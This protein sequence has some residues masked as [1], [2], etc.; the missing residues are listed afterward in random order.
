MI[1]LNHSF[2][3]GIAHAG[4]ARGIAALSFIEHVRRRTRQKP[5][6]HESLSAFETGAGSL[7]EWANRYKRDPELGPLVQLVLSMVSGPFLPEERFDGPVE[8]SLEALDDWLAELVRKLLATRGGSLAGLVSPAPVGGATSPAYRSAARAI[9]NWHDASAF[10]RELTAS[11]EGTTLEVLL[12]AEQ[13]MSG[14]LIVLPSAKRS[15]KGWVLDC[16][17]S[18]L[19]RALLGLDVYA[20]ALREGLHREA[21][22]E[23]YHH[24]TTIPMSEETSA[25]SKSPAK[26]QRRTFVAE[27]YGEQ[28]FDMHAKPGNMTR[29]HIWTPPIDR[30]ISRTPIYIGHCGKHL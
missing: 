22:A 24:H 7:L 20:A 1:A 28:Y 14:Q 26:R 29:V 25:V 19:H 10:D 23:R 5:F 6:V 11:S 18:E 12:R 17:A 16:R 27:A 15:A 4:P 2:L 8:P 30:S 21:C 9:S 3:R 13:E